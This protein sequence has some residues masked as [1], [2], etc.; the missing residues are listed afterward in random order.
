MK[1]VIVIFLSLMSLVDLSAQQDAMFTHYSFNTLS[2]NSG[3][4][5]SRDALTVTGLHRSQWVSFPGAPTSQTLTLHAPIANEKIGVG[6]SM[7]NDRIGPTQQTAI[8]G[9]FAYK[10]KMGD[11]KLAFGLKGGVNIVS[12]GLTDLKTDQ[13]NDPTFDS[14]VRSRLLPNFGFGVYYSTPKYYVGLS[15]PRLLENDYQTNKVT[16]A[17]GEK[18]HYYLIGGTILSLNESGTIKIKPTTFV[19]VT[20]GAPI[21]IDLTALFYFKD[22]YWAGPM[23]RTGDALGILGGVSLTDQFSLG[24][25]FDWSYGN[26]TFTNNAGSH[27]LMLRYD[28]MY[29]HTGKILSP[30]YF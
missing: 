2:V 27:E 30:R 19:K 10:I 29:N 14:D 15:T 23:F 7:L 24:Y 17:G 1:K 12:T 5:G 9:D 21:E 22:K 20:M 28:F 16:A 8:Y 3:Y 11:G 25:S 26:K 6:F 18:R 13:T 4:A